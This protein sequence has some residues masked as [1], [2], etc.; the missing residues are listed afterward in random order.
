M[1]SSSDPRQSTSENNTRSTDNQGG[2]VG[3]QGGAKV[4]RVNGVLVVTPTL[5]KLDLSTAG[6]FKEQLSALIPV[7]KSLV[8]DMEGIHFVDSSGLGAILS[9]LRELS[10]AGGDLRL[11]CLQKRVRVMFELVRMHRVLTIQ[12][13]VE[14]AVTSL[15][16]VPAT[17]ADGSDK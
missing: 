10:A 9:V 14:E 11:C 1:I 3:M 6:E 15:T 16:D 5:E 12:A 8:L 7:E 4:R 2:E 17:A 13:T